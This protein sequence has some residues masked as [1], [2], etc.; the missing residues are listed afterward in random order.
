F[1]AADDGVNGVELWK[2]DG[3]AAGTTL[4]KD[5]YPGGGPGYF[6]GFYPNSSS[7]LNLTNVNGTLFFAA[8]DAVNGNALWKSDGTATGTT[9]LSGN[10]DPA[11]LT[12]VNGTLFFTADDRIHGSELWKSDG[13]AAGTTLVK[14]LQPGSSP[15]YP[16][17][18]TAVNGTLFLRTR[19]G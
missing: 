15:S 7:P 6:G 18:L 9:S 1:F 16:G 17:G 3:T 8:F 14:D 13:T 5:I 2:S 4:V 12:N 11:D 10:I 19:S